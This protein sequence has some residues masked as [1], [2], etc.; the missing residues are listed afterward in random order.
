M[1]TKIGPIQTREKKPATFDF[2][3]E[4]VSGTLSSPVVTISVEAGEDADPDAVLVGLP[5]VQGD[6]V[7]QS[8]KYQKPDVTYLLQ[9]TA[10]D[11]LRNDHT[12]SAYLSAKAVA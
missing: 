1:S 2:S 6:L 5:T 8:V 9:C 12:V 7:I 10:T 11:S 3:D 4:G